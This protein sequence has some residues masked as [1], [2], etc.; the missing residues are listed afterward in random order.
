MATQTPRTTL[1]P[2]VQ[3]SVLKVKTHLKAGQPPQTPLPGM[4]F[5][6]NQTLVRIQKPTQGLKVKTHIRAGDL[7]DPT[8]PQR[9][10]LTTNHN[11]TLVRTPAPRG[12][13]LDMP[14]DGLD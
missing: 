14:Y 4:P 1:Q 13:H 7:P 6:H 12:C 8:D 11:Q 9:K 3:A 5:N 2:P 10:G